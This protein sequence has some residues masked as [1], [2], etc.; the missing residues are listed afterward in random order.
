MKTK[1]EE[2]TLT[3]NLLGVILPSERYEHIYK[4]WA[5]LIPPVIPLYDDTIVKDD[6]RTVGH[7]SEGKREAK[8]NDSQV[9]KTPDNAC[10]NFI[11]EVVDET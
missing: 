8:R 2:I 10:R 9:Y 6:T 4:K 11:M 3:H 7:R 5:Y 1:Y